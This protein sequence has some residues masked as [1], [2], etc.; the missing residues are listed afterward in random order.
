LEVPGRIVIPSVHGR[1]AHDRGFE[2]YVDKTRALP[3]K[4]QN[5]T[6]GYGQSD[7]P[8]REEYGMSFCKLG[9]TVQ[10]G[11]SA[12]TALFKGSGCPA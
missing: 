2:K 6:T 9:W 7:F 5:D 12:V 1:Y 3:I 10:V 4:A 8:D 11:Q